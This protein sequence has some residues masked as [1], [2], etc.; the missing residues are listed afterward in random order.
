M[1]YAPQR[2]G[3]CAWAAAHA[4]LSTVLEAKVENTQVPDGGH[5]S[6]E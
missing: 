3:M 1:A 5:C 6:C 4:L 2:D